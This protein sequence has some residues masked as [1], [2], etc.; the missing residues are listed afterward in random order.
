LAKTFQENPASCPEGSF[1]GTATV[2]TPVL[3]GALTGPAIL[4]SHGG[5]SFPDVEFLLQGE[6]IL[7]VLDGKTHIKD[8]ITTSSFNTVPDAP[9]TSFETVLPEGPHSI[10]GAIKNLCTTRLLMP[11]VMTGQNGAVLEKDTPVTVTGCSGVKAS[12]TRRLT[13]A[14][15]RS[16]ALAVCHKKYAHN[17][18]KRASCEKAARKRYPAKTSRHTTS[19]STKHKT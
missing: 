13:R 1:I 7:L 17:P 6:G 16:K 11:T 10:L 19:T 2:H 5:E 12:K 8:G 14:Q 4:V 15:K 18:H 3:K 9:V